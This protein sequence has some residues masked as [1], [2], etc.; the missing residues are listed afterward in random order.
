MYTRYFLRKTSGEGGKMKRRLP[1]SLAMQIVH[2]IILFPLVARV[3][4]NNMPINNTET[5]VEVPRNIIFSS[6]HPE[7]KCKTATRR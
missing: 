5:A 4:N 3:S 2:K 1:L 7:I 6:I